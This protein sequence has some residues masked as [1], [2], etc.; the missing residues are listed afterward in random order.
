M[1]DEDATRKAQATG[2]FNSLAQDF[3]ARGDCF[4]RS[5]LN[6]RLIDDRQHLLGIGL[7]GRKEACA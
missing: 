1:D 4:F 5:V 6:E 7:G 2:I 3:D